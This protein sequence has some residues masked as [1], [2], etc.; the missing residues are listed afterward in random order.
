MI[1]SSLARNRSLWPVSRR[2]FG[3]MKAPVAALKAARESRPG[4]RINLQESQSTTA[5]TRQIRL[6]HA[7]KNLQQVRGLGVLH[8]RLTKPF[9]REELVARIHAVVRRSAEEAEA[10][11]RCGDL[12]VRLGMKRAEIA[13]KPVPL[14]GK[15]Y[16]VLELM[17]MRPGVAITK[18][19]F[20]NAIYGGMDEPELKIID[21]FICKLRNKLA[22]ASGG[23]SYIETIRGH[24][25]LMRSQQQ[26]SAATEMN[27][28]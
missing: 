12:T 27:A 10:V 20:L 5:A 23:K 17:A 2:S 22:D 7:S 6:L 8:G 15:E 28:A 19:M 3:R 16:A 24:G 4:G 1:W 13:R 25:Y 21:V 26:T 9:L 14:T 11:V 18:Q